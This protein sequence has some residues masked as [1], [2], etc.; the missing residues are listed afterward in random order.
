MWDHFEKN[1]SDS[2][3]TTAFSEVSNFHQNPDFHP[4]SKEMRFEEP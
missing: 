2:A 1:P 4:I 3:P